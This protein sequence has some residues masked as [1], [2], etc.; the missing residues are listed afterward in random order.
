MGIVDNATSYF[1]AETTF[2]YER[3]KYPSIKRE[4]ILADGPTSTDL[5]VMVSA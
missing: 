2:N 1:V 5:D 4:C 3:A